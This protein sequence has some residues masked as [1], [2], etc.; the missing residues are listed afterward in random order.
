MRILNTLIGTRLSWSVAST[1]DIVPLL[2]DKRVLLV[3]INKSCLDRHGKAILERLPFWLPYVLGI[4]TIT[5]FVNSLTGTEDVRS[6][7]TAASVY[8]WYAACCFNLTLAGVGVYS[9]VRTCLGLWA[10]WNESKRFIERVWKIAQQVRVG[11]TNRHGVESCLQ[12]LGSAGLVGQD[13]G[14]PDNHGVYTRKTRGGAKLYLR[15]ARGSMSGDAECKIWQWS[16]DR[17][18]WTAT[19][20][21]RT[22]P[23]I[24]TLRISLFF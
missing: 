11:N 6:S 8:A 21:V 3:M 7:H 15:M 22:D 10:N 19:A 13:L 17:R 4:Y 5:L 24:L 9:I 1:V 18:L 23:V 16:L 2:A 14:Q 12:G 20:K